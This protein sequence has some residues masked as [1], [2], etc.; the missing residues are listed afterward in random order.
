MEERVILGGD[1]RYFQNVPDKVRLCGAAAAGLRVEVPDIRN[2]HIVGIFKGVIPIE[3][4]VENAGAVTLGLKFSSVLVNAGDTIKK[5]PAVAK[6][7]AIVIEIMNINFE[8]ALTQI[9]QE[10]VGNLITAFRDELKGGFDGEAVIQ[11]HEGIA[12]VTAGG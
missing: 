7:I 3:I 11:I 12:K 4:A 9:I 5:L 6:E 10:G 2:G 1:N 8:A